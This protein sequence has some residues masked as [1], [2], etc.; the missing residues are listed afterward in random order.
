[1]SALTLT[2]LAEDYAVY[3]HYLNWFKHSLSANSQSKVHPTVTDHVQLCKKH[4]YTQYKL[5]CPPGTADNSIPF[6]LCE[7]CWYPQ[8]PLECFHCSTQERHSRCDKPYHTENSLYERRKNVSCLTP[9]NVSLAA[10]YIWLNS[11]WDHFWTSHVFQKSAMTILSIFCKWSGLRLLNQFSCK[12]QFWVD[13]RWVVQP[14]PMSRIPPVSQSAPQVSKKGASAEF[15]QSPFPCPEKRAGDRLSPLRAK[16]LVFLTHMGL[17]QT[18]TLR[19]QT[20]QP[21]HTTSEKRLYRLRTLS[22]QLAAVKGSTEEMCPP[23]LLALCRE[24]WTF[25]SLLPYPK[26]PNLVARLSRYDWIGSDGGF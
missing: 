14:A 6:F 26:S 23:P 8:L 3:I 9:L 10:S 7:S 20:L 21:E 12:E 5:H 13:W 19:F 4:D 18:P 11:S 24:E 17:L 22:K 1:M 15:R 2:S 25:V 16:R